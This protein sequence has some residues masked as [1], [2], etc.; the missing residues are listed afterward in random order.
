MLTHTI[1]ITYVDED[2]RVESVVAD[3]RDRAGYELHYKVSALR[4][5]AEGSENVYRYLAWHALKRQKRTTEAWN[6]WTEGVLVDLADDE[7]DEGAGSAA[8]PGRPTAPATS[9]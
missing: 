5:M 3:Q 6:T 7:D 4:S 9:S 2:E 8:D 1:E